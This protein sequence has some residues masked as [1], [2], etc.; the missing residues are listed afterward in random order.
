MTE[1]ILEI[2]MAGSVCLTDRTSYL[3]AHFHQMQD[4]VMFDLEEIGQLPELI[5]KLLADEQQCKRIAKNAYER[6][7]QEFTWDERAAELIAYVSRLEEETY[8]Q[9]ISHRAGV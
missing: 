5:R 9:D 3:S 7:T 4:I 1:R 6:V 2:M 8:D